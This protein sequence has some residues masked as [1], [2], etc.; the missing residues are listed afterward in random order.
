MAVVD[1]SIHKL[2]QSHRVACSQLVLNLLRTFN[3]SQAVSTVT[4]NLI[5]AVLC[6]Y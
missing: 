2:S 6:C 1:L 4:S 3:I 5:Q